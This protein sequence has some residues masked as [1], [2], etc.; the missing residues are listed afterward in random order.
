MFMNLLFL[1]VVVLKGLIVVLINVMF[2]F[3][4]GLNYFC[5]LN[6]YEY[7]FYVYCVDMVL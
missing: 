2:N 3:L 7:K 1:N 4:F 5:M 6:I